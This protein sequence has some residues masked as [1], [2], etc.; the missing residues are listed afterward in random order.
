MEKMTQD[1]PDTNHV[2]Q[3]DLIGSVT[4][5]RFL[6]DFSCKIPTIKDQALIAKHEA[7]LNGEFPVYLNQ[8]VLKVHKWISYLKYTLTDYPSFWRDSELGYSLRDANV[9]EAVYDEVL[10]FEDAWYKK[11]WGDG[12]DDK[13]EPEKT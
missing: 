7:M 5:R 13:T 9:I 12:L 11:I 4:K 10:S 8:G 2:F 1:I 6:G 3:L